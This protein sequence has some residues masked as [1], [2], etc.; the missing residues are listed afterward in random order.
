M[1]EQ[2]REGIYE[3]LVS[4][5]FTVKAGSRTEKAVVNIVGT[6]FLQRAQILN[7]LLSRKY[8]GVNSLDDL[9]GPFQPK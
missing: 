5:I 3:C 4:G 8:F 7:E 2:E 6:A 1:G 9:K